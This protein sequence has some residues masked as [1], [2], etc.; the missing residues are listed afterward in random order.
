MVAGV[1]WLAVGG[2]LVAAR[3]SPEPLSQAEIDRVN[4]AQAAA[5][6]SAAVAEPTRILAIGDSYTGGS[7]E[8]GYGASGWPRLVAADLT[9]ARYRVQIEVSAAGG[10][11]YT[12]AGPTGRTLV[13][14]AR[15]A[16]AGE[17]YDIII[18]FG[19]RNDGG[20]DEVQEAATEAFTLIRAAAPDTKLLVIGPPWVNNDFPASILTNRDAVAAAAQEAAAT[21]VDPL[22][23]DWFGGDFSALIGSDG[24][25]PTDEGHRH[26]AD[27]I[28]PRVESELGSLGASPAG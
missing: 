16:S 4:A 18:L 17:P 22:Q 2:A 1:V 5:D 27:L 13:D 25:H 15:E 20:S 9:E 6:A 28:L 7:D 3:T 21:F 14:L 23:E 11:G 8:G 12:V 10:S 19:S 26:M 24:V